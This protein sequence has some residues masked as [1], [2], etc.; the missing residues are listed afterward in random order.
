MMRAC[1]CAIYFNFIFPA[2]RLLCVHH[3]I[4]CAS[5]YLINHESTA[6]QTHNITQHIAHTCGGTLRSHYNSSSSQPPHTQQQPIASRRGIVGGPLPVSFASACAPV[7]CAVIMSSYMHKQFCIININT[8]GVSAN[9]L[10][11]A[12]QRVC[13]FEFL[14]RWWRGPFI[15]CIFH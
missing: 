7:E 11:G 13:V 9:V 15:K 10:C 3:R 1:V 4:P 8:H 2:S 12:S 14:A 5:K 6:Q